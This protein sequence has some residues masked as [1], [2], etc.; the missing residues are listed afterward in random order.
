MRDSEEDK[1]AKRIFKICGYCAPNNPIPTELL[2]KAAG[3]E[4]SG[5]VL[6]RALDRLSSL[7]L[8]ILVDGGPV[9]HPL[10]AE[11]AQMQDETSSI[12]TELASALGDIAYQANATGCSREDETSAGAPGNSG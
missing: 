7:G 1:L 10:L 12:L 8:V 4:A 2:A 3:S 6:D 9:L 11:F 5:E